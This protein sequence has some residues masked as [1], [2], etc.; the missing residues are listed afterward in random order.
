VVFPPDKVGDEIRM[1]TDGILRREN[2]N[3]GMAG[4]AGIGSRF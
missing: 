3:S 2:R 4:E 1:I